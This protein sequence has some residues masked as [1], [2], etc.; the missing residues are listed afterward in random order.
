[1]FFSAEKWPKFQ[2]LGRKQFILRYGV[3]GWGVPVAIAFSVNMALEQGWNTF[4]FN[5][6]PS[7]IIFPLAGILFGRFLWFF[8]EKRISAPIA[9]E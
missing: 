7:L 3:L 1:M 5:L 8:L 2:K 4:L 6:I 9:T